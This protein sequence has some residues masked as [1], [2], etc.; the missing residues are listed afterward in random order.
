M[1]L[2]Q[3]VNFIFKVMGKLTIVHGN[4]SSYIPSCKA[5]IK[6]V[7]FWHSLTQNYIQ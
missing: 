3:I 1:H 2:I 6:A 5:T 7:P 4:N